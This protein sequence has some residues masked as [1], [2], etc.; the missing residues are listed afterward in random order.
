LTRFANY[1]DGFG[2]ADIAAI[3]LLDTIFPSRPAALVECGELASK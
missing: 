1:A 2:G 3:L